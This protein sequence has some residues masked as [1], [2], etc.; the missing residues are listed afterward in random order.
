MIG[1]RVQ[2]GFDAGL[3]GQR[4][5]DAEMREPCL[6]KGVAGEQAM[7]IGALHAAIGRAGAVGTAFDVKQRPRAVGTLAAAEMDLVTLDRGARRAMRAGDERG[8]FV[9]AHDGRDIEQTEPIDRAGTAIDAI[10]IGDGS[11]PASDSRRT[12][13]AHGRRGA[14]AP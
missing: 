11:C 10:G 4:R 8:R 9:D 5:R 14:H 2:R 6:A 1:E 13:R 3:V 12:A 7:H